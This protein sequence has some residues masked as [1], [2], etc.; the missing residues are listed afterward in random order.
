VTRRREAHNNAT[1]S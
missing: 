1:F